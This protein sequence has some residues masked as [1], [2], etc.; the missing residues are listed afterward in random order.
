MEEVG[1]AVQSDDGLPRT[2]TAVDDESAAGSRADDGVLVGLDGAEHVSHPCGPVAAQAGDE[3]GLVVQRGV[4]DKTVRGEHL[5][6]VVADP[7]AGPAKPAAACQ[8]HRVGVG[9]S[10]EGLSRGERQSSSSRRPALSVRPSRPTY[11]GSRLSAPTMCPR[12]RSRP[13]RRS[14]R[15]RAVSRWISMSRSIA[16]R[17]APPGALRSASRRPDRS[18]IDCSR[19]SAMAAKCCSSSATSAGS[20]LGERW[21]GRSN[22]LVVRGFTASAP[23][24]GR[25]QPLRT[26]RCLDRRG[27]PGG[28]DEQR[29]AWTWAP[30]PLSVQVA[31]V[32]VLGFWVLARRSRAVHADTGGLSWLTVS[33]CGGAHT[34]ASAPSARN[35]TASPT[36]GSTSP[37]EPYVADNTRTSWISHFRRFWP[38]PTILR[39][40]PGLAA[41][42]PVRYTLRVERSGCS[43]FPSSSAVDGQA[44]REA[45]ACR[46]RRQRRLRRISRAPHAVCEA[47]AEFDSGYLTRAMRS[48]TRVVS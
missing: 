40:D 18:A 10:E 13:K 34:R 46:V 16:C 38:R 11:T 15:R 45:A 44:L 26:A 41:R 36:S 25:W 42:P 31:G 8:T 28:H 4:P 14:A 30:W 43:P 21:P 35:R 48:V 9:G 22:A 37:R 27:E 12:H 24:C 1:G 19:H 33:S 20:A 17:P 3:S 29:S 6:P 32:Q 23:I 2:R 39:H 47:R 7:T 5:V